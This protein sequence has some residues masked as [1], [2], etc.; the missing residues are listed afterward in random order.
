MNLIDYYKHIYFTTYFANGEYV[1]GWKFYKL[2][3]K[4][5][6][7]KGK[8]YALW[9]DFNDV[10]KTRDTIYRLYDKYRDFDLYFNDMPK[11][12]FHINTE[13]LEALDELAETIKRR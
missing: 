11:K 8:N 5:A 4:R 3:K 9:I 12:V 10:I 1:E 13:T 2:P 7:I 6:I